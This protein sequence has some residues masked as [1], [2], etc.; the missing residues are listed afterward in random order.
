MDKVDCF[1]GIVAK[2]VAV[3]LMLSAMFL[4]SFAVDAGSLQRRPGFQSP[5]VAEQPDGQTFHV[6]PASVDDPAIG[7]T[8]GRFFVTQQGFLVVYDRDAGQW[9]YVLAKK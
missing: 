7:D 8:K 9:I 1:F 2:R 5:H 6:R 3:A 4:L